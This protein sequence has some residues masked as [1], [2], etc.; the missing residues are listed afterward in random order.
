MRS[1]FDDDYSMNVSMSLPDPLGALIIG[2]TIKISIT[3]MLRGN[4]T[5]TKQAHPCYLVLLPMHLAPCM[6]SSYQAPY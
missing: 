6:F 4:T 1:T 5:H 2:L 3:C